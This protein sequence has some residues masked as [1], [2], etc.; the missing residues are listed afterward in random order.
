MRG[1]GRARELR[2]AERALADLMREPVATGRGVLGLLAGIATL[3][4]LIFLADLIPEP[5]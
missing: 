4:G 2:M 5:S 1:G 3:V